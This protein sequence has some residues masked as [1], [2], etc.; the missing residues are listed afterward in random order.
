MT[1]VTIKNTTNNASVHGEQ[2]RPHGSSRNVR[3]EQPPIP[4]ICLQRGKKEE[5]G[6]P[7]PYRLRTRGGNFGRHPPNHTVPDAVQ[8]IQMTK[9]DGGGRK[10]VL[11][12]FILITNAEVTQKDF[13]NLVIYSYYVQ[14]QKYTTEEAVTQCYRCQL[15]GHSN[16]YYNLQLKCLLLSPA[17]I[18]GAETR[19]RLKFFLCSSSEDSVRVGRVRDCDS[20]DIVRGV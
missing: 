1:R 14:V 3:E 5:V 10:R 20:V 17:N 19:D 6:N 15:F 13:K 9:T 8:V 18:S 11:P 12:T 16:R 4:H 7:R 2:G